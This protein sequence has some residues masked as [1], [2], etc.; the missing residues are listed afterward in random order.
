LESKRLYQQA[1]DSVYEGARDDVYGPLT[2]VASSLNAL[3]NLGHVETAAAIDSAPA[4]EKIM[5]TLT[6][7]TLRDE[8]EIIQTLQCLVDITRG[9]VH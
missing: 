8:V 6:Y 4:R 9:P 7:L 5:E 3:N 2:L 1:R